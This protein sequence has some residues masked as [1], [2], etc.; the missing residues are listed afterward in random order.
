MVQDPKKK[1]NITNS[2]T[3]L[4]WRAGTEFISGIL[5]GVLLGYGIDHFFGTEPWGMVVMIILGAMAGFRN[6]FKLAQPPQDTL[7]SNH[8]ESKG[9][10]DD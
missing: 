3:Q 8:P 2:L 5:A 6:I 10:K 4:A 1:D 9:P 7:K